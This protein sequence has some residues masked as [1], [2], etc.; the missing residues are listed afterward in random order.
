V[1]ELSLG[2]AATLAGLIQAPSSYDPYVDP[3]AA[4]GRRRIVLEKMVVLGWAAA[5]DAAATDRYNAVFRGGLRI[6]TTLDPIVQEAA[7]AAIADV[8][9]EDG[10]S[11]ALAAVK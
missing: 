8:I 10:P 9:P 1:S 3:E 7:E 4:I 6:S 2:E 5:G 11:A